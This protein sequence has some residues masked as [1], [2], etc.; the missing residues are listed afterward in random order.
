MNR[1]WLHMV[2]AVLLLLALPGL[3]QDPRSAVLRPPKGAK[4]AIVV[5]EDLQCPDCGRAAPLLRQAS[6]TYK[7]PQV[8]YDFPLTI[9]NWSRQAAIF[10]KFFD[11]KSKALGDDYRDYIFSNQPRIT[12]DNLR[13]YTETFAAQHKLALPFAVDPMG[14]L[15]KQVDQDINLGKRVGVEH[16][17]TIYV[18]SDV[19][20]GTPFVEVVDRSQLFQMIDE[21]KR[22][23]GVK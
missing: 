15:E 21:M 22:Q 2:A 16:T 14:A 18:V 12:K 7:I 5:F 23:A 3:A 17:P 8:R 4:V 6:K 10:A 19:R 20:A 9:H 1:F 13:N 11:S